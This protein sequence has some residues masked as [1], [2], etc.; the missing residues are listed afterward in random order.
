MER[1]LDARMRHEMESKVRENQLGFRKGRG[2]EVGLFTVRQIIDKRRAFR[3]EVACRSGK[4]TRAE[5][6]CIC[7][8]EMDGGWRGRIVGEIYKETR[9]VVRGERETIWN[10]SRT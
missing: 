8:H 4:G 9:A 5:R 2:T 7:S 6:T 10:R 1:I 3:K